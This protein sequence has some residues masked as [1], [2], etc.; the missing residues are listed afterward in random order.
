MIRLFTTWHPEGDPHRRGEYET[1]L[2]RNL[3]LPVIGEVCV[4]AEGGERPPVESHRLMTR[5]AA[6]RPAYQDFFDWINQVAAPS[7]ISILANADIWFDSSIAVVDRALG[8]H[9]CY[10]LARW[11]DHGVFNRNDSQDTW[12]FR[13]GVARVRADFPMGVPRCDNRLL[14]ELQE[15]GY[16]VR[17]PA[18]SVPTRHAHAGSRPEY[19]QSGGNFVEPPYRY[20]WP[21]NL[22]NLPK[23]AWHNLRHPAERISW[24]LDRTRLAQSLPGR[25]ASKMRRMTGRRAKTP[26]GEISNQ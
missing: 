23:T 18:L 24:R 13:G 1:C 7:D 8:P 25:A 15:A 5:H 26:R 12:V 16:A 2:R 17:N 14:Y 21:H 11:E 4:I 19:A 20:M 10:A 9:E 3:D 22:W 6:D